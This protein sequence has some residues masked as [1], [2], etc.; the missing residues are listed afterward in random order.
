MAVIFNRAVQRDVSEVLEYYRMESGGELADRFFEE[1]MRVIEAAED[2]PQKF[3]F[4]EPPVRRANLNRF[5]YHFLYRQV[6]TDI[7]VLVVRHNKRHP[8]FGKHRR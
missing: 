4:V 1:L 3:H 5:P 6:G 8:N 7:R 2:N